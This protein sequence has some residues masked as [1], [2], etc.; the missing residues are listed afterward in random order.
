MRS[1]IT[2]ALIASVLSF[3][4]LPLILP[5]LVAFS[6]REV[7]SFPPSGF[8]LRWFCN[9]FNYEMFINGLKVSF[10]LGL[11]SSG[12]AVLIS[13]PA[14]YAL[15][16]RLFRRVSLIEDMY[17]L[18]I[19]IPQLVLSFAL[20]IFAI[21]TLKLSSLVSLMIGHILIVLPFAMRIIYASLANLGQDIEDVA[22]SLGASRIKAFFDVVLPN[23]KEGI[24]GGFLISF[25]VSFNA[26]SISMFLGYGDKIPLPVTMLNYLQIRYDPTIA[27]LSFVVLILSV[28]LVLLVEKAFK[29]SIRG[30]V[31]G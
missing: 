9:I 10:I 28:G 18:P 11:A 21:K 17:T 19:V 30:G 2:A 27:A 7:I 5:V 3:T 8:T 13:F 1:V 31:G 29:V 20:L 23:I 22:V 16:R 26:V 25:V 12:I 15:F 6:E 14:S 4:T 24:I